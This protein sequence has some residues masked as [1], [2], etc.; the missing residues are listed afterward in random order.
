MDEIWIECEHIILRE[1]RMEDLDALFEL[2]Y[3]PHIVAFLPDWQATKEQ[4][5]EWLPK[6]EIK[7]NTDFKEA[8]PN[9]EGKYL[10]LTMLLKDTG[11]YL[12]WCNLVIKEELPIPNHELVYGIT[13]KHQGKGYTTE[14]VKGLVAYVFKYTNLPY[15]HGLA[16]PQN[17]GSNQ[18][19][20]KSGF[21]LM[22]TIMIDH[23]VFNH[24]QLFK[25][26]E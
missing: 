10:R 19:L 11:E 21:Q 5:R 12:G 8:L 2:T 13:S 9:V 4:R 14:A 22:D 15:I 16:L 17:K 3:E 18:V 24:Y 1:Y 20:I 7:G 25:L 26:N 6:Y 23:E